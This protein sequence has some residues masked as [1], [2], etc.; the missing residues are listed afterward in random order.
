MSGWTSPRKLFLFAALSLADLVLTWVLLQRAGD[1]ACESNPVA[2]WWLDRLGWPGL[3][4]FK[5]GIVLLVAVLVR[6]VSRHRSRTGERLLGFGCS[7]LLAVVLYSGFL[8]YGEEAD[9]AEDRRILE[10]ARNLD[11]SAARQ[12]AYY[13]LLHCLGDDLVER[14][15]ALAEAVQALAEADYVQAPQWLEWMQESYPDCT[16]K[17]EHLACRLVAHAL[18]S[19][20]TDPYHSE[21]VYRDLDAQ[22]QSCFGRPV[23]H[24]PGRLGEPPVESALD[25]PGHL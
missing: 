17:E 3:A 21:Q 19:L 2:A 1:R 20:R 7:A 22:F 13:A 12:Q 16:T 25:D 8:V 18:N 9:A 6:V 11:Q 14:R 24:R 15:I 5:L 10:R 23:P 4:G